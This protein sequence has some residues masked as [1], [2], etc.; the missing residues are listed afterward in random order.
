MNRHPKARHS[1]FLLALGCAAALL[2]AS[3][4]AGSYLPLSDADLV[5]LAPIIVR[6]EVTDRTTRLDRDG[7]RDLPF[8]V[9]TLRTLELYKGA[10]EET[11]RV[12]IPGGIVGDVA[13]A[14]PGAPE[15]EEG[16]E[17]VLMLNP[18]PG[19]FGEFGLSE[20]GLSKFDLVKDRN[21]RAFAVRPVF[22]AREDLE[23]SK[24]LPD[25]LRVAASGEAVPARDAESFLSALRAIGDGMPLRE[26]AF[27]VPTGDLRH[28]RG[29]LRKQWSNLGGVEP[30]NCGGQACLF[31]WF[32]ENGGSPN[33]TAFV[34]GTQTSLVN[35]YPTCGTDQTCLLQGAIN[36]WRNIPNTDVRLSGPS[37]TGNFEFRLDLDTAHNGTS[38]TTPYSCAVNGGV[39]GIGGPTAQGGPRT[40]KGLS[41]YYASST[42]TISMRRWTCPY[43]ATVFLQTA[44]HEAG[45]ALG[46]HHPD[47]FRSVHSTTTAAQWDAAI[48]W[49]RG[50][51]PALTVPQADDIQATQFY[52][53]TAAPG[54]AP[55]ANFSF[56]PSL[57]TAGLP[58]AFS[59]TSTNSPTGWVWYFGDA[60]SASNISRDRNPTH[61]YA[62]PGTYTVELIAG[63][64]NGGSRVTKQVTVGGSAVCIPNATTLCLVGGRFEVRTQWETAQASGAGMAIPQSSDTGLFWFF[65]QTNIEM[66][67]KVLNTCSFANRFWVFAGGLTDVKVTMTV[68]DTSNGTVKT[69]VNPAGTPFQPIQDTNAF[70]TCP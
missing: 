21:G 1:A 10:L 8:R 20:F 24:R 7:D 6:A 69:Y 70:A 19:R 28:P 25:A 67:L 62:A 65:S 43:N 35:D 55:A 68:T 58:A 4:Y 48:M 44:T 38:W 50:R 54:P 26:L 56:S 14:V 53:G 3:A 27:A 36:N 40:F 64:L 41:P 57:P 66:V 52:Y 32:W 22:E 30:G 5:Q 61:T 42:A 12:V 60:S 37:A 15:F 23:M 29:G 45:H 31:K 39:I 11:F 18:L 13:W 63:N 46:L 16:Y 59:D 9:V 2:P 49:S 34:T 47:Q 51:N 33:A 17:V